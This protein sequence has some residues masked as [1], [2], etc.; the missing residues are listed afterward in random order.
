MGLSSPLPCPKPRDRRAARARGTRGSL[1]RT[2]VA[3]P[4]LAVAISAPSLL[5]RRW[6]KAA[7]TENASQKQRR[8]AGQTPRHVREIPLPTDRARFPHYRK[9]RG[10]DRNFPLGAGAKQK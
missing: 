5:T 10:S 6:A 8:S 3:R 7:R 2:L 4:A 9:R 1:R